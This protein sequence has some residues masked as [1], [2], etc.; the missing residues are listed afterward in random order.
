M[1][2]ILV[3]CDFSLSALRGL[4]FAVELAQATSG[5]IIVLS[6]ISQLQVDEDPLV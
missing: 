3:P 5:T 1:Q 4:E 2:K 6:T